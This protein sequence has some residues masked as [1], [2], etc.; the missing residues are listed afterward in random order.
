MRQT[1][2]S[3]KDQDKS[4]YE[5][6]FEKRKHIFAG[7]DGEFNPESAVTVSEQ[8]REKFFEELWEEGGLSFWLENYVDVIANVEANA[9]AYTFWRNK[10]LQ[11][12]KDPKVAEILAPAVP[13]YFFGTKRATV[14]QRYYEVYNQD[15]VTLIDTKKNAIAKVVPEGIITQDGVLHELDILILATGFNAVTGGLLAIDIKGLKGQ[16]LQGK[17]SKG[18]WTSLGLMTAGFPNMFFSYG[19]QG[20]TTFCNGPTCA[21]V[22]GEWLCDTLDFMRKNGYT[23]LNTD[24]ETEKAWKEQVEMIGNKSLIPFTDS[25]YIGTNIPGKPK[26]M[27]N[28][29]GGLVMYTQQMKQLLDSKFAGFELQ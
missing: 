17:W 19:P 6:I 14:E 13:P 25:E 26:E 1:K 10:V 29:L 24:S 8:E 22:Q 4:K 23:R 16:T 7:L 20:P 21:E 9:Y 2:L 3:E 15:N 11:R 5:A 18:A 27:L 28:Y 12:I